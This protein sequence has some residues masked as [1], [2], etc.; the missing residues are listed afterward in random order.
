MGREL[1]SVLLYERITILRDTGSEVLFMEYAYK[2]VLNDLVAYMQREGVLST[3]SDKFYN[4][5]A[6]IT[7]LSRAEIDELFD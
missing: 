2:Q 3:D 5:M 7:G 4:D 6:E 1:A